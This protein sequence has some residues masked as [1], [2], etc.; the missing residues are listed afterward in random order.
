MIGTVGSSTSTM[1]GNR[2][3]AHMPIC[4]H[5]LIVIINFTAGLS[6]V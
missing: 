3:F 5:L 6:E 1:H 4:D 2:I